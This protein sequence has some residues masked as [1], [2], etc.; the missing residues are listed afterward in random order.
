MKNRKAEAER[1]I[2]AGLAALEKA[3]AVNPNYA[4]IHALKGVLLYLRAGLAA[5]EET[6]LST[7]IKAR[8]ALLKGMESNKNLRI[9]YVF[10]LQKAR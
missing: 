6:R 7:R 2:T 5:D 10:Y 8:V 4:E 1:T 9:L 3:F